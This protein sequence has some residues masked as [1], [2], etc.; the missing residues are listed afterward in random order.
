MKVL[1]LLKTAVGASWAL[2]QTRELIKLGV[3]VHLALPDG[4]MVEKYRA[5]G[6]EVHI[7]QTALN[8]KKPWA[9]IK[10][11]RQ[12]RQ[13]V[14]DVQ[15]DIIHS[16]FV[17]TTLT[18]R[19]ALGR[20]DPIPRIFHVPGPLHLEH[21]LFR[22]VDLWTASKA[23]YWLASCEWTRQCY[24]QNGISSERLGLAYYGVDI[25]AHHGQNTGK[26]HREF[27]IP[28]DAPVVGNVAY[29]YPPKKYLGQK[30]GLKGH[31]DLIDAVDIV[32]QQVANL[33]CVF[34]GGPWGESHAYFESVKAYAAEKQHGRF[35]F[36][37]TRHDV[38]DVYAELDVAIHPSHSENVGGAV[39]SL[40][41]GVATITSDVG[42]FPDL[43]KTDQTG[44][45]VP[46]ADPQA[47][48]E[49]IRDALANPD[50]RKQFA[51]QGYDLA[52]YLLNVKNNASDITRYYQALIHE[53][54][55]TPKNNSEN[56]CETTV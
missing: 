16:H 19:L 9:N 8:I 48:A 24:L 32:A 14:A 15:P 4:P 11:F 20:N 25:E 49:A 55:L 41:S 38:Q 35:I 1:H 43:I 40:L 29:F 44:W 50:K 53:H 26:L 52:A 22:R 47:L 13:L 56:H 37:G 17:A 51:A 36:T 28:A 10:L 46:K 45:L 12:F 31:E 2:R 5:Q 6:V 18:M 42:G 7:L 34:V 30:R 33:H 3:E 39:E 23:D 21:G 54:A 27:D